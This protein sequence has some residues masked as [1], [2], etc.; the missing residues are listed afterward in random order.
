MA[1]LR[2]QNFIIER[3]QN[4]ELYINSINCQDKLYIGKS[5]EIICINELENGEVVFIKKTL[6]QEGIIHCFDKNSYFCFYNDK[7]NKILPNV[8]LI[9]DNEEEEHLLYNTKTKKTLKTFNDQIE[10]QDNQILSIKNFVEKNFND[11]ITSFIDKDT[12]EITTL[13]S[14]L[15]QREISP[16]FLYEVKKYLQ[17]LNNLDKVETREDVKNKQAVKK[18]LERGVK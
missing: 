12:L 9:C 13:Y 8:Y 5:S 6:N 14:T 11:T 16:K 15:Q 18:I 17:L 4:N 3:N 1:K 7:I 2:L 10:V